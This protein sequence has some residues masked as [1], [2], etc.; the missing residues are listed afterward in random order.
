MVGPGV[1]AQTTSDADGRFRIA[2]GGPGA[3]GVCPDGSDGAGCLWVPL[4]VEPTDDAL[5]LRLTLAASGDPR[6]AFDG[7]AATASTAALAAVMERFA[8]AERWHRTQVSSPALDAAVARADSLVAAAPLDR[9]N[10]VRDSAGATTAP[11]FDAAVAPR[12]QAFDALAMPAD[13]PLVRAAHVLWRLHKVRPDSAAALAVLR[14]VPADSPLWAFEGASPSGVN[15]VLMKVAMALAPPDTPAPDSVRAY[16]RAVAYEHADPGVRAQAAGVLVAVLGWAGDAA[17]QRAV[18]DRLLQ[19]FPGSRQADRLRRDI[20]DDRRVRPGQP[21]PAFAFPTLP[22]TTAAVTSASLRGSTALLD[23]WGT[24]CLPCVEELPGL[25]ALYERYRAQG[26]EILSVATFDTVEAVAS[27]RERGFPM[28]WR[29]A[30][31]P[32]ADMEPTRETFEFTGIPAYVLVGP[33]GVVIAE[34]DGARG[35][36]LAAAL[37]AHF[38]E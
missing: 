15:N 3:L 17:G 14:G 16:L 28:P 9:K 18:A 37:A 34:G 12:A 35:D 26:F 23:F 36:D 22:D 33:D 6:G 11:L 4:A 5:D 1:V 30:L 2:T 29:H 19:E 27:F 32:R 8:A 38:G 13:A 10:A 24:W 21:L 25:H 7:F 20:A 31:L